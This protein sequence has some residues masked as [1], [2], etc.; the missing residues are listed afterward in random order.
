MENDYIL[1][2]FE[3]HYPKVKGFFDSD[4]NRVYINKKLGKI[5]R[6]IV[7]AHE[8]QHQKCFQSKC[9]CY[10]LN[11]DFLSEYH[12]FRAEFRFLQEKDNVRYWRIYFAGVIDD[13]T[14]YVTLPWKAH[15]KA[16]SKVCR[17]EDFKKFAKEFDYWKKI[18]RILKKGI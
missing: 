4:W 17:L 13:L 6:E 18:E 12:A 5:K 10:D 11:S 16:L 1:F 3:P 14:R 8:S 15:F 2:T 9:K 7:Y